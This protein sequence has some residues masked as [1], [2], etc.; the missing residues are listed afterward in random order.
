[1]TV[2]AP[3]LTKKQKKALAFRGRKGKGKGKGGD[4]AD[5]LSLA[6]P[7][8]EDQDLADA[9]LGEGQG[10]ARVE[11]GEGK[12]SGA[13]RKEKVD[14]GHQGGQGK[15]V[16]AK[17]KKR[18]RDAEGEG[19]AT[20]KEVDGGAEKSGVKKRK[21]QPAAEGGE[22]KDA[23][24]DADADADAEKVD[25]KSKQQRLILFLGNLKY[26][27][28]REAIA[29]HF[30]VCDPPPTIRLLNPKQTRPGA[31]VNK[32]KGCAFLEFS[33][34]PAVQQALKL[35]HSE[36]DGRQINV[37]L[38]AGGGGKSET[39]IAK[40]KERNKELT[41]QR[42]KKLQ[43]HGAPNEVASY[44][45]Q[46]FSASSG[47]GDAPRAKRTWTVENVDDGETHRGGKNAKKRGKRPN[48]K[49]REWGTGV[50][51]IPVG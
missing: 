27:T 48:A 14:D 19:G 20:G 33:A 46:R 25:L 23:G 15:A 49:A 39:R 47:E 1:M 18:K 11:E 8:A 42:M 17:S 2:D 45:P 36:L 31:T 5:E 29:E 22:A 44:K 40:L 7:V 34:R 24:G 32:S 28:T 35:H 37:E 12:R 43:K 41:A 51:A 26:T 4:D 6:V 3:K 16:A 10:A 50:N 9:A 21:K 38:T 30:A 13:G